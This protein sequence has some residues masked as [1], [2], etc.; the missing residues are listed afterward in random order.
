MLIVLTGFYNI[1][2][3]IILLST[4]ALAVSPCILF[5]PMTVISCRRHSV[6]GLSLCLFLRDH[7]LKVDEHTS[8]MACE[9]FTI[10]KT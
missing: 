10:F 6:F 9:N 2:Y 3:S 5:M 7:I 8:E 4:V 1:L